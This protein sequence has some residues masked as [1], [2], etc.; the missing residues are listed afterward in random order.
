MQWPL[1]IIEWNGEEEGGGGE[2]EDREDHYEEP[3]RRMHDA[4]DHV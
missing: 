2:L 4:P 1:K 3:V